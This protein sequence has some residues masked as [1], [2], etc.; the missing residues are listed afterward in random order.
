MVFALAGDSTM[1]SDFPIFPLLTLAQSGCLSDDL[2]PRGTIKG[3]SPDET[4]LAGQFADGK[5]YPGENE[6]E[7]AS[8]RRYA[9]EGA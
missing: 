8:R 3:E 2:N 5:W 4:Q 1:T 6:A 7:G 9:P